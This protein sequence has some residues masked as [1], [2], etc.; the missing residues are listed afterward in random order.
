MTRENWAEISRFPNYSVSTH[1]RIR[2][3]ITDRTIG[4]RVTANGELRISL[5]NAY[6]TDEF[7]IKNIVWETFFGEPLGNRIVVRLNR[8]ITDNALWNLEAVPRPRRKRIRVYN[9]DTGEVH[10]SITRAA[11]SVGMSP[12]KFR[13][14]VNQ[15]RIR[16]G[17]YEFHI[18]EH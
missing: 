4:G 15:G 9:L 13:T 11:V 16:P 2:N 5:R 18:V 1:G 6:T 7:L 10:Q 3:N 12:T 8:D 14:M 17:G